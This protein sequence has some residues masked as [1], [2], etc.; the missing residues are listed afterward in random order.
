M[1]AELKKVGYGYVADV[2]GIANLDSGWLLEL[3]NFEASPAVSDPH[4]NLPYTVM[5]LGSQHEV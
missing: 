1:L 4:R 2:Q 3:L 5:K